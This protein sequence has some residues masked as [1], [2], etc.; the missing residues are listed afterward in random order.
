MPSLKWSKEVFDNII[1]TWPNL[2]RRCYPRI[3]EESVNGEY[4]SVKVAAGIMCGAVA[5]FE[6]GMRDDT[7]KV[8]MTW[9]SRL[10]QYRVP[11]YWITR[12]MAEAIKR[13]TPP[14]EIDISD[15]KLPFEA[16]LFMLPKDTIIHPGVNEGCATF[17]SYYRTRTKD[18]IPFLLRSGQVEPV[19]MSNEVMTILART[20]GSDNLIHWTVPT[21]DKFNL[22]QLDALVQRFDKTPEHKS[23]F[24]L[25][26]PNL[27]ENG[28]THEDNMFMARVCHFILGTVILMTARP[29]LVTAGSL[30]RRIQKANTAPKEFWK[31]YIIG[32]HYKIRKVYESKGGTHASPR[33]HW[34]SG[35]YRDQPYGP[36]NSL[37]KEKWVQPFFRGGNN[38][39]RS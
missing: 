33:G 31:P 35:F 7:E 10:A 12:D 24:R 17:V 25:L 11:T 8:E 36:N 1:Q 5:T 14:Y 38:D 19:E 37:R 21:H 13:T 27:V 20:G 30:Q 26:F 28:M 18:V 39:E 23:M 34:V 9:A 2:W 4:E 6:K 22:G 16:S 29:D 15:L 32:E 3:Y